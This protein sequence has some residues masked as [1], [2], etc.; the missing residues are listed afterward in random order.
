M[1]EDTLGDTGL[2]GMDEASRIL[3]QASPLE[4]PP[5]LD[6]TGWSPAQIQAMHWW[7]QPPAR[8]IPS[9]ATALAKLLGVGASSLYE[10]RQKPG[11]ADA[12]SEMA[13]YHLRKRLPNVHGALLAEA[14]AGNIKA[15]RLMY[16]L[17]GMVGPEGK[18][19][20]ANVAVQLV[21]ANDSAGEDG[22]GS[23]RRLSVIDGDSVDGTGNGE[24][25]GG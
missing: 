10:W 21:I 18:G 5:S 11:W 14:E 16:E 22:A 19:T 20:T 24:R 12:V 2:V 9:T 25:E 23:G 7:A 13:T 4:F 3:T 6:L 17:L 1:N 8:R 15:I